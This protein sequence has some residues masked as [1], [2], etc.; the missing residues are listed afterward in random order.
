VDFLGANT[1]PAQVLSAARALGAQVVGIAFTPAADLNSARRDL[2][3]LARALPPSVALWVG[4][5]GASALG[6][7][8]A[9][10]EPLLTWPAI[11]AALSRARRAAS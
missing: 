11:D 4:G 1:P 9:R 6:K 8:P 2:R 7:M 5:S 3:N 10:V